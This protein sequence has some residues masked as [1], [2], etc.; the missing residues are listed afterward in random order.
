MVKEC[1]W[2][3]GRTASLKS[4]RG[5]LGISEIER[6]EG[7]GGI[8]MLLKRLLTLIDCIMLWKDHD[9][10]MWCCGVEKLS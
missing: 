4:R 3:C 5:A 9:E 6:K 7:M 10:S 8:R 1:Q 2:C